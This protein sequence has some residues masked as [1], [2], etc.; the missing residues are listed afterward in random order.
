[1]IF[2]SPSGVQIMHA[3]EDHAHPVCYSKDIT[4]LHESNTECDFHFFKVNPPYI[5]DNTFKSIVPFK[6]TIL[7]DTSYNFF[8]KQPALS[9]LLRGPPYFC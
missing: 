5:R 9:Y 4:H 7:I 3:L 2:L 6:K 8:R 1:M